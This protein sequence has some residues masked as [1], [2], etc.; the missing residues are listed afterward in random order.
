MDHPVDQI[1]PD[2]DRST[3]QN[4]GQKGVLSVCQRSSVPGHSGKATGINTMTVSNCE[5]VNVR[6]ESRCPNYGN[7]VKN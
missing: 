7:H 4:Y 1:V 3:D 6:M 5:R 2:Q